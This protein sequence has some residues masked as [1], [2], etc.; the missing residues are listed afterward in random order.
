MTARCVCWGWCFSV[1]LGVLCWCVD[2][3]VCCCVDVHS[4]HVC[5]VCITFICIVPCLH[6]AQL[7]LCFYS[8]KPVQYTHPH[9]PYNTPPHL[10]LHPHTLQCTR[11][12]QCTH[13]PT[14]HRMASIV[15]SQLPAHHTTQHTAAEK[16]PE[17]TQPTPLLYAPVY[18][19]TCASVGRGALV[20]EDRVWQAHLARPVVDAGYVVFTVLFSVFLYCFLCFCIVVCARDI[21]YLLFIIVILCL[22]DVRS[23]LLV[24]L[25]HHAF[26]ILTQHNT[27]GTTTTTIIT[28]TTTTTGHCCHNQQQTCVR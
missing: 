19:G 26:F 18:Y 23:T 2:T 6:I 27:L 25:S 3:A 22:L 9:P 21:V 8:L 15:R 17:P 12:L 16:T 11:T 28:T 24:M 5:Y 10:T 14:K 13:H 4:V 1:V 7:C 20:G